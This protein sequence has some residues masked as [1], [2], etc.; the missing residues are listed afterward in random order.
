MA[1]FVMSGRSERASSALTPVSSGSI[2]R[3]ETKPPP[4]S[5]NYDEAVKKILAALAETPAAKELKAKAAAMGK[6]FLS[7]IEGKVIAGSALGG[8]LAAII[9]TNSELPMQIPELPLDFIAPGL[10][11]KITYE[12][13]VQKPTGVGLTL[14]SAKGVSLSGSYSSTPSSEGKPAEQKGG[15]TLTIPL[16]ASAKKPP[17]PTESEKFRAETARMAAEQAKMRE[18][19]KTPA[20]RAEDKTFL[21]SYVRSQIRDP[22]NP[23][24]PKK[25]ED[26]LMRKAAGADSAS[27]FSVPPIV[28]EAVSQSGQPLDSSTRGFMESRFGHNFSRVRVH[29]NTKAAESA[30]SVNAAAYTVGENIVFG[31]GRF[32]PGSHEGQRLIAHELAH[33]VQQYGPASGS[34]LRRWNIFNEIAGWFAGDTFSDKTLTDYLAFLET[35][36]RIEDHSDSDNKARAIVDQWSSKSGRW[37]LTPKLKILL[38]REMQSGF[39]GDDDENAILTLLQN[40]N[41]PQLLEI[42]GAGGIDPKNL[43]SDFHGAEEKKL[44]AFYDKLFEGGTAAVLAGQ[45]RFKPEEFLHLGATYARSDL[46]ALIDQHA[47]RIVTTVRDTPDVKTDE[48]ERRTDVSRAMAR[49]DADAL[50]GEIQK[51]APA[52]RET[53]LQDLLEEQVRSAIRRKDVDFKSRET[54][55]DAQRRTLRIRGKV[56]SARMLIMELTVET[57]LRDATLAGPKNKK[58]LFAQT[59]ALSSAQ[60]DAA[61]QAIKPMTRDFVAKE[62]GESVPAAT[63]FRE[64]VPG[65]PT[66]YTTKIETRAPK[67]LDE[68][69]AKRTDGRGESEH[70][71]ATK[72]HKPDE[73]ESVAKASQ[74]ETDRIYGRFKTGS[75]FKADRLNASGKIVSAGNVHDL[76]QREESRLK[77]DPTYLDRSVRFWMFYLLQNDGEVDEAN[78][79]HNAA[80]LFDK[81]NTALNDEAK[82]VAKIAEKHIKADARRLFEIARGWPGLAS[83][84]E[85][86]VQFFKDPDLQ[87]DRR[88]LWLTYLIFIHEYLHTLKDGKYDAYAHKLGGESSTEGNT[89]IEGVDSLLTETVW[90]SAAPRAATTEVRNLVE[91]D[92]IKAGRPFDASLLPKMP[93]GRYPNYQNALRLVAIVGRQNLYAAYF[94]GDVKL[95]GG[96]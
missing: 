84:G 61:Q 31:S 14:T 36:N 63:K 29:T 69:Y 5:N 35:N 71:D 54:T 88:F 56:M 53:A 48:S 46:L 94:F 23:L 81:S 77:E 38:I 87:E 18:G 65:D 37:V 42:F 25:K 39:T 43:D 72:L 82:V 73:I 55:D 78:F 74:K 7:S 76:W 95:I 33:V 40:S 68:R 92:A 13:P 12:G 16:G 67:I 86:S 22:L 89:L 85:V 15:L 44:H 41:Y 28:H 93:T 47:E 62:M 24:G 79:K 19:L 57:L 50:Y 8:A 1:D 45:K 58:E 30:E 6:D 17:G 70:G 96:A 27:A 10:K 60:R 9:A 11:A 66:P 20:E 90:T 4:K 80:P 2:Q 26:L 49:A 21:D 59:K 51:L 32:A 64:T 52:D 91:P 3:E 83:G 75:E 34:T